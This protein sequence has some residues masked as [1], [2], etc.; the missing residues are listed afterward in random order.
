MVLGYSGLSGAASSFTRTCRAS[1]AVH[2][3]A[4][5]AIGR[6]AARDPLRS[7]EDRGH[8]RR[9]PTASSSTIARLSISPAIMV[10][11][12]A[13]ASLTPK[14]KGKVERPFRL[15]SRGLLPRRLLFAISM[16]STPNFSIGSTRSPIR[17]CTRPR[18]AS[19]TRAFAEEKPA[20]KPCHSPLSD[21]PQAG[22]AGLARRHG[23]RR[24]QSVQRAGHDAP[25][26]PRHSCPCRTRSASRGA[27][28]SSPAT[29]RSRGA[30]R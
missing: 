5:E 21:G 18:S 9:T 24:R 26:H 19:S 1:C 14:T 16:I 28:V 3:A 7:D 22:K 11:S 25:P 10:S 6:R 12:P 23:E 13:L 30:T 20:L 4:L 27:G 15:Y 2:I 29:R 17:A 8:R